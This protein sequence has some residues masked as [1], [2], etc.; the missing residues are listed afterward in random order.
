[1]SV[2]NARVERDASEGWDYGAKTPQLRPM[3]TGMLQNS[4]AAL[5]PVARVSDHKAELYW[6]LDLRN[7][8]E[9]RCLLVISFVTNF[10]FQV[11]LPHR[12][13]YP[14]LVFGKSRSMGSDKYAPALSLPTLF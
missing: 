10:V 2:G 6:R 13:S 9:A 8:K 5:V 11:L 3:L 4:S 7:S 12:R 14:A 1:M